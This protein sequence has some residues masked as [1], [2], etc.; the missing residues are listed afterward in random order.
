MVIVVSVTPD[1]F[2]LPRLSHLTAMHSH[3]VPG[4]EEP[5]EQKHDGNGSMK[6]LHGANVSVSG[7]PFVKMAFGAAV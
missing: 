2:M 4:G 1:G 6:K 5:T 3:D 7:A